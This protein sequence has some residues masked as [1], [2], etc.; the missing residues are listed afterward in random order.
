[1]LSHR[2][3]LYPSKTAERALNRHMELGRPER[4]P[5][6]MGPLPRVPAQ[7]VVAG[8]VPSLRQEAPCES[9]G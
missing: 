7:A 9:W 8:H 1:M 4:T 6:E 2:F 3:R 5:V